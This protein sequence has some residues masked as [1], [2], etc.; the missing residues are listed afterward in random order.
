VGRNACDGQTL[1]MDLNGIGMSRPCPNHT[2]SGR[3]NLY[4]DQDVL[5]DYQSFS[6]PGELREAFVKVFPDQ[7]WDYCL[8]TNVFFERAYYQAE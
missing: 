3:F 5:I 2:L 6:E 1:H 8:D 4:D 7:S